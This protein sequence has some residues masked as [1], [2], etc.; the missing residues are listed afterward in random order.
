M[1]TGILSDQIRQLPTSLFI[2]L[3]FEGLRNLSEFDR[4]NF[5]LERRIHREILDSKLEETR[6][7]GNRRDT[8]ISKNLN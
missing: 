4:E 1:R 7:P 3:S 6:I 5:G 2:A 8:F